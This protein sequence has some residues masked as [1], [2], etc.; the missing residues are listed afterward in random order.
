[1]H[2][3]KVK[4]A[5][6]GMQRH[7]WEQGV[8]MQAF[9]EQGDMEAV[10]ALA[11]EAVWR[12]TPDGRAAMIGVSDAITDPCAVG[13]GLLAAANHTKAQDLLHGNQLLL[14]WALQKAPRNASGV[15]YH[16]NTSKQ[17][18]VDSMYMLPPY[19]AAS[20]YYTQALDNL[21]GYW[22]ALFDEEASLMHHMWDDETKTYVRA[23]HWGVGNGWALAAL[24]RM[25]NLLPT[26]MLPE[27]QRIAAMGQTL[28]DGVLKYMRQDGLFHDVVDDPSTFVET[29]LSQMLAYTL[30]RGVHSGWL[31]SSYLAPA[32]KLRSAARSKVDEY[33]LVQGVCGSPSFDK[34]G[35]APEGQ[36]FYLL[37]E[38]AAAQAN[39]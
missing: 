4:L 32:Q 13:E 19:L 26:K 30:Y 11:K 10:V 12:Q 28:V 18:W 17:F 33:G 36:A 16:L 25:F 37:M 23:A 8:A 39:K 5:L 7:S 9:L 6:L 34:P 22:Q 27:K 15:L 3:E 35:V 21:Y 29:N 38:S 2:T 31:P 20:G 24:A 14:Q 1:M